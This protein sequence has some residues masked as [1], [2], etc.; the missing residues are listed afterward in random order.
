MAK[1]QTK[2]SYQGDPGDEHI[3]KVVTPVM[4]TPKPKKIEPKKPSWEIK[5]R[6]Y[7]LNSRSKPISYM[8]KSSNVYWFDE[9]K[10]YERELRYATNQN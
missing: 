1:K 4:E 8:L 2:A 9:E 3:E 5:D 6:I 7:N 10:G